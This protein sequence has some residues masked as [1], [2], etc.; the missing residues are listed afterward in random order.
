[1][2]R[3][4][5]RKYFESLYALRESYRELGPDDSKGVISIEAMLE[6]VDRLMDRPSSPLIATIDERDLAN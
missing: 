3:Q 5:R 6:R 4:A 1:M 2:D